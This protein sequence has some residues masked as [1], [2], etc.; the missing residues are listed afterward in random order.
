MTLRWL[1]LYCGEDPHPRRFDRIETALEYLRR[2]ERLPQEALQVMA[3]YGVVEPP[4]ARRAYRL[5]FHTAE[6]RA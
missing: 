1:D 6:R 2:I 4:L 3:E 5:S